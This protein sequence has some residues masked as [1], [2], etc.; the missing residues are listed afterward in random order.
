MRYNLNTRALIT[1][2]SLSILI[3]AIFSGSLLGSNGKTES[4]VNRTDQPTDSSKL[5]RVIS[6]TKANKIINQASANSSIVILDVRKPDDYAKEHIKDAIN[7]DFKSSDFA[8]QV[9]K[10]D[11][12]KTYIVVCYAGVRSKNTMLLM[13]KLHF[14][15]VY[16]VKGGMMKWKGK[17]MSVIK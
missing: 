3:L 4:R 14:A 11:K 12:S 7:I 2:V 15:R 8:A 1:R 6:V 5:Y 17:K 13:A 10:L 16:S 9:D